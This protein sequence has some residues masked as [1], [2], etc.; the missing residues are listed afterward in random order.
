M[1]HVALARK[2]RP[3]T[4]EELIGQPHVI[5]ALTNSLTRNRLHHAYLFTGTHGIGKTSVARLFAKALN[6]E[7]GITPTPCL[8]C[9][10]CIA[11]EQGRHVDL[12]EIDAASK[13]RVE[14]T[15][16]LLE[17]VC[18][19]P[20]QGRFKVY[21]IDEVHMLSMHSFNALLKTLEEPPAHVIFLLATT[22]IHKLPMTVLSRC[23]QFHLNA[24]DVHDIQH[25]LS[26]ILAEESISFDDTALSLI[27]K[28][29][30]GSVRD[31]LS[32]LD[33]AIASS[34]GKLLPEVVKEM[35]GY[36]QQDYALG[37]LN[38]LA[39][40]QVDSMLALSHAIAK[41]GGQY[42][43]VLDEMLSYLHQISLAQIMPQYKTPLL[44]PL[45]QAFTPE[46]TQLFYQ[47]VLKGQQDLSLAPT[48]AI[49]FEMTLL[50]LYTF[51]PVNTDE[52]SPVATASIPTPKEVATAPSAPPPVIHHD[53]PWE[54]LI[55]KLQ[56]S[57]LA[58]N[59]AKQANLVLSDNQ[60][61][62]LY[63]DK[64]HRSL[65]TPGV[66]KILTEKL[67]EFYQKPIKLHLNSE[68]ST[69]DTPAQKAEI[70]QQADEKARLAA[71][72]IDPAYQSLK[73]TFHLD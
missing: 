6:C 21:L 62:H 47:I 70:Q 20:T 40:H 44:A 45:V 32:L 31:A 58:L 33:Q 56:L 67:S 7:Q 26:K 63:F 4:F 60:T 5:K 30:Q 46:D 65:F 14:D 66:V 38:A 37:I 57:G 16:E 10:S 34:E 35:L 25:Q 50:R 24:L 68:T 64:N 69:Q 2:Y 28:A 52:I 23:L 72:E 53:T 22:E 11:I 48:H 8:Q 71:L 73:K 9:D 18:Y 54:T 42:P 36:T 1:A 15:R 3:K 12:I 55:P 13:T 19:S 59:A 41:E 39:T 17:N 51:Q 61:A 43:Y 27:A 29:S 49:G